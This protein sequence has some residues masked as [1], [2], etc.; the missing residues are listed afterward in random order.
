MRDT[1]V[2]KRLVCIAMTTM[3]AG[4]LLVG[5]GSSRKDTATEAGTESDTAATL[6]DAAATEGA[7]EAPSET[8]TEAAS[9]AAATTDEPA[10]DAAGEAGT[11][12]AAESTTDPAASSEDTTRKNG[13][14][15][16]VYV[17]NSEE[18]KLCTAQAYAY[19][20]DSYDLSGGEAVMIPAFVV[21]DETENG[22][23]LQLLANIRVYVFELDGTTLRFTSGGSY[24]CRIDAKGGEITSVE[25]S[26]TDEDTLTLCGGD[27]NLVQILHDDDALD[28]SLRNNVGMYVNNYGYDIDT[29]EIGSQTYSINT[30]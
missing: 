14:A 20:A 25:S 16:F 28:T 11:D 5:C 6:E 9:D 10:S 3:M 1:S 7:T 22:S 2:W 4:S 18:G 13:L 17:G 30:Q 19:A 12:A 27:E 24:P 23:S 26:Y 8:D 15:P 21:A 29:Y